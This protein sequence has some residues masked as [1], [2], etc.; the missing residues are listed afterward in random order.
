MN[1]GNQI[2]KLQ[3]SDRCTNLLAA[4][5]QMYD[6]AK[7]FRAIRTT[8]VVGI[9][10]AISVARHCCPLSAGVIV[11]VS[12]VSVVIANVLE[13][14]ASARQN[15]AVDVQQAADAY[16]FGIDFDGTIQEEDAVDAAAKKYFGRHSREDLMN[17]YPSK[18]RGLE[19]ARA[20]MAC[21]K[22]NRSW[23]RTL[24][25]IS[26]GATAIAT[27]FLVIS[28]TAANAKASDFWVF[29]ISLL[30]LGE[31]AV[32]AICDWAK[33][34]WHVSK[35]SNSVTQLGTPDEKS[36]RRVQHYTYL[37]R[38]Q[39]PAPSMVYRLARPRMEKNV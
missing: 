11:V 37:Y 39:R 29:E 24:L 14:F 15:Y 7:R 17:W 22:T 10:A 27:L 16:M 20:V 36:I 5:R 6:E 30:P 31:L 35:L 9:P 33:A 34:L 25:W 26:I 32:G 13:S 18:I 28:F 21:Q 4:Q 19:P 8:V 38:Q 3:N 12:F 23:T 1:D 2:L